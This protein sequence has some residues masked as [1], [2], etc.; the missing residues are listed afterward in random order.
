MKMFAEL[1]SMRCLFLGFYSYTTLVLLFIVCKPSDS[2]LSCFWGSSAWQ[3]NWSNFNSIFLWLVITTST[4]ISINIKP[5]KKRKTRRKMRIRIKSIEDMVMFTIF[6]AISLF[7]LQK[8]RSTSTTVTN[9]P[10][11]IQGSY[12]LFSTLSAKILSNQGGLVEIL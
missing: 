11:C 8:N 5:Q 1:V 2:L 12:Q 4:L 9:W 6:L 10:V 3:S 7:Y